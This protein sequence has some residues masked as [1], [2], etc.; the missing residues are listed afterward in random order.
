MKKF[1]MTIGLIILA[2]MTVGNIATSATSS[3]QNKQETINANQTDY[4]Y[5]WRFQEQSVRKTVKPHEYAAFGIYGINV[6]AISGVHEFPELTSL[7]EGFE[8]PGLK[9][10]YRG[11]NGQTFLLTKDTWKIGSI[12]PGQ[13]SWYEKQDIKLSS[14][15]RIYLTARSTVWFK[16]E[17]NERQLMLD[18]EYRGYIDDT[19]NN[20]YG[21]IAAITGSEVRMIY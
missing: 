10:A 3:E 14:T 20:Y 1:L 2:G 8:V 15:M 18:L 4:D 21:E 13:G 12:L 7:F 9:V 17:N 6:T 19:P 5:I 16:W 11:Y